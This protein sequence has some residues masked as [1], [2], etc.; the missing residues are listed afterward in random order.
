MGCSCREALLSA[1]VWGDPATRPL[2]DCLA[3]AFQEFKRWRRR[4]HIACSQR[5]FR[6]RHLL[7]NSHGYYFTQKAYNA[8]VVLQWLAEACQTAS[9]NDP[10]SQ[11]LALNAMAL[12]LNCNFYAYTLSYTSSV[13]PYTPSECQ[14]F[15]RQVVQPHGSCRT[16][17]AAWLASDMSLPGICH[18]CMY[19]V[20]WIMHVEWTSTYHATLGLP[21]SEA[22]SQSIYNAGHAFLRYHRVLTALATRPG[23]TLD[24]C[25]IY[26]VASP[27]SPGICGAQCLGF[28]NRSSTPLSV[29][30][31]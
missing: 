18:P 5:M 30:L 9:A 4:H 22:E 21:R 29:T 12:R 2:N 17:L 14:D 16:V 27:T 6:E 11:K 10:G 13:W 23:R 31:G 20:S 1:G 28:S 26:P 25:L 24:E 3:Q 7:K 19:V 15:A 8:R